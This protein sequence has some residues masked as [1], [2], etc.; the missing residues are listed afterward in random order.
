MSQ[1]SNQNSLAYTATA[2]TKLSWWAASNA[3]DCLPTTMWSSAG[4]TRASSTEWLQLDLGSTFLVHDLHIVPRD[5]SG[6]PQ[7]LTITYSTDGT[8]WR[9]VPGQTYENFANP[10]LASTTPI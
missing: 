5:H 8:N 4:H 9:Q 3:A 10:S 6:S 1:M 2:S 7:S